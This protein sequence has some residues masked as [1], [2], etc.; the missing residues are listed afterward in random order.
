[1]RQ[2]RKSRR[3]N[4]AISMTLLLA[5][6]TTACTTMTAGPDSGQE[7]TVTHTTT[8]SSA[9]TTGPEPQSTTTTSPAPSTTSPEPSTTSAAP[10]TTSPAPSTTLPRP[11][12]VFS[13]TSPFNSPIPANPVIDANSQAQVAYL[14]R[15][16]VADLWEFG[17]AIYEVDESTTPVAIECI[18]RW[19]RC[20]LETGLHRV[21]E[22]AIPAPG[23]DGTLVVIDWSE[24][25]TVEMWQ[26]RQ[27]P[28]RSWEASWGTTT[29]LDGSGVPEV[30]GTGSGISHLAGVVRV[31]E[32]AAGLIPHALVFSTNNT[33]PD[34]FREPA[35]KTDGISDRPDC[36]PEGARIQLAPSLDVAALQLS[37]AEAAIARALQEYGA[38]VVDSGGAPI[39]FYFEIAEDADKANPGAVYRAN[40]LRRDYFDLGA[41]PWEYLRVL[42][43]W[44][45]S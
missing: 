32:I 1:M 37:P 15:E 23:N 13:P 12:P 39:A 24:N 35:T 5:V 18:Q 21:P 25:R 34:E 26:A 45:G 10:S 7:E 3:A 22:D 44:D 30:F 8:T 38:Y 19:G 9:V 16:V 11:Q 2:C 41:I 31:S 36:I 28:D 33:C 17:I 42:A 6:V 14:Q 27:R 4:S 40:G 29:P 43:N 20:P